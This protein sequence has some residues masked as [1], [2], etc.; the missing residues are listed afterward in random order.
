MMDRRRFLVTSLAGAVAAPLAAGAQPPAK[1]WRVGV[2]T[3]LSPSHALWVAFHD[4]LREQGYV[5]GT[6]IVLKYQIY[7]PDDHADVER[8]ARELVA[9]GVD[10]IVAGGANIQVLAAKKATTTIPI[11][12]VGPVQ[13]VETG[14]I[15][16]LA[17]PGA[18]VTGQT[19]DV[20]T[21]EGR[22]A[23]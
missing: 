5:E 9:A 6:N 16:S 2:M 10:V 18:N 1:V 7:R 4:A 12:M 17:R 19:W 14:L 8:A 22:Q 15:N 13:V 23:T 21:E 20:S 3:S 11:V